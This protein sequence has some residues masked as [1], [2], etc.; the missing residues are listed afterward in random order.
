V[1]LFAQNTG[2]AHARAGTL[3]DTPKPYW[4]RRGAKTAR[5]PLRRRGSME[6]TSW[7]GPIS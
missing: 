5:A 1:G 2:G 7:K 3:R 4:R 6:N